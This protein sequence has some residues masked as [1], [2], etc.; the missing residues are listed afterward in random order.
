MDARQC[1][2]CGKLFQHTGSPICTKCIKELDIQFA[3]VRDYIYDNPGATIEEVCEAT[4]AEES[5]IHRWLAEGRLL[6]SA[7]SPIS[8]RCEKCGMPILTGKQCDACLNKLRSTLRNAADSMKP[9]PPKN[10]PQTDR[11]KE[12]MHVDLRHVDK[13]KK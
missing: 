2:R 3:E 12:K 1:K 5:T 4:E 10:K 11:Q 6:L 8:L 13:R 9:P 7:G